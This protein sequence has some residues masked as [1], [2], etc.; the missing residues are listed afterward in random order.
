MLSQMTEFPLFWG[1]MILCVLY[2]ILFIHSFMNRHLGCFHT[3]AFVNNVAMNIKVQIFLWD[4]DLLILDVHPKVRLLDNRAILFLISSGTMILF[5]KSGF[6]NVNFHRKCPNPL[7]STSL[8]V[9]VLCLF[10]IAVLIVVRW[11]LTEVFICISLVMLSIFS[12]AL[13][14]SL[15]KCLFRFF[16]PF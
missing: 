6:I 16:Y 5:A 4:N 10:V 8:P 9:F 15:L 3:W 11:Y 14:I 1:W 7:S 2:H 12:L 13:C